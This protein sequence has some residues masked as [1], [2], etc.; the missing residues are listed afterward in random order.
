MCIRDRLK[1]DTSADASV[2]SSTIPD[3]QVQQ[4]N[5]RPSSKRIFEMAL[6]DEEA[7]ALLNDPR[8]GGV[9]EPIEWSDEFL[10]AEQGVRN[11]LYGWQRDGT[12]TSRENWGLLRHIEATNAWGSNVTSQ[13]AND[14][15][16]YHLDGTGVDFVNQEGGLVRPDHTQWYDCLLYTSDAADE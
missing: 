12:S 8:V 5:N 6:T 10:D 3:R 15:Y 4:V 11:S 16:G 1:R 9:N 2:S 7:N 13:R 14:V